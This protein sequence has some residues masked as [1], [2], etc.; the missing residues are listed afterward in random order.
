MWSIVAVVAVLSTPGSQVVKL[1]VPYQTEQA[2][3]LALQPAL[4]QLKKILFDRYGGVV[5]VGGDCA[6]VGTPS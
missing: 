1:N 2:C 6:V 5:L 4:D 3:R